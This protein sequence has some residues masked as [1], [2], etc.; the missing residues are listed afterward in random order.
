MRHGKSPR[1]SPFYEK[2]GLALARPV[3]DAVTLIAEIRA[4]LKVLADF[5]DNSDPSDSADWKAGAPR[6][7]NKFPLQR[8]TQWQATGFF[9]SGEVVR[10]VS[11]QQ[12]PLPDPFR[13]ILK[14]L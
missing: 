4:N 7:Y 3:G 8:R 2:G 10:A 11:K 13:E 12:F 1:K 5:Y 14:I 9:I 6:Q